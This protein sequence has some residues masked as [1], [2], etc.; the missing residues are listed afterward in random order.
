MIYP[1][2]QLQRCFGKDNSL[3][4][5]GGHKAINSRRKAAEWTYLGGDIRPFAMYA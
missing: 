2:H 3:E 1:M 5:A 4:Y